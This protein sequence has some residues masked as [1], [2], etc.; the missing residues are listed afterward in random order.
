MQKDRTAA[1]SMAPHPGDFV[2]QAA[3]TAGQIVGFRVMRETE[4]APHWWATPTEIGETVSGPVAFGFCDKQNKVTMNPDR[5]K[6][7]RYFVE[8][9]YGIPDSTAD[10]I[11]AALAVNV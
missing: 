6:Q 11:L 3:P 2:H 10:S 5:V 8:P 1:L 4:I 7:H 9:V